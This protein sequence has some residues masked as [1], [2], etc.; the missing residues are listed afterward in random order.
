MNNLVESNRNPF[1][2]FNNI[3]FGNVRVLLVNDEPWFVGKDVAIALGYSNASK[4]VSIHVDDE[5]KQFLMLNIADSQDG[6]VSAGQTKT[7]IVN[8]SGLYSLIL[9]SKL[10]SAR[11][12][13]HWITHDVIPQIRKTGSYSMSKEDTAALNIIHAKTTEEK[14]ICIREYREI[15]TAPL[16]QKIAE[17]KPKAD[18]V[19]AMDASKQ[20][21]LMREM[22]KKL[23]EHGVDTGEKRLYKWCREHGLIC[24]FSTEP[25]QLA[26]NMG[27][28]ERQ[29]HKVD[30]NGSAIQK[31]TT[32]VTIKGQQYFTNKFVTS[33][34]ENVIIAI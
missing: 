1:E 23:K 5:D 12:F 11:K 29:M 31:F 21:I 8:E 9:R 13:K 27:I 32:V 26:M 34:D 25:T 15:V 33:G 22:A 18:L 16:E 30:I 2:V 24:K 3:E 17:Q 4:A 28:F 14:A 7:A 19:D 10:D 20:S 6:N